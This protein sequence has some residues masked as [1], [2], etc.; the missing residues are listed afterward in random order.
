MKPELMRAAGLGTEQ[1]QRAPLAT[2]Q[3]LPVRNTPLAPERVIHLP[4]PMVWIQPERQADFP[5][6]LGH[7]TFQQGQIK[8]LY[9]ALG[10]LA[11]QVALRF[12]CKAQ[13]H[14]ARSIHV[15]AMRRRLGYALWPHLAQTVHH[16]ILFIRP[17]TWHGQQATGFLHHHHSGVFIYNAQDQLVF[18]YSAASIK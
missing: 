18:F 3:A 5:L 7:N 1:H 8:L 13:H 14:Q 2:G 11:R 4:G 15:Q 17:A 6:L 12:G 10:K 9:S 16:A